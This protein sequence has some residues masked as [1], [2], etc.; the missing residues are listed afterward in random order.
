MKR[1]LLMTILYAAALVRSAAA[2]DTIKFLEP[3]K[4]DEM[5]KPV[6]AA[7]RGK[8]IYALDEKKCA[9]LIYDDGKLTKV[10][11]RCGSEKGAFKSP[12]GVSVG[13]RGRVFVADTGNSRIQI[14]DENGNFLWFFGERGSAPGQLKSPQS[15]AVGAD[16]R[17]FVADTGNDR[18][19]VFTDE[20][21]LL[22]EFGGKASVARETGRFGSPS[23]VV[24]DPSDNIYV[25]DH[26]N[27]RIQ[28]FDASAKFVKDFNLLG[29]DFGVDAYGYFYVLDPKNGKVIEQSPEGSILGKFGSYGS[30][31]GQFK[32]PDGVAVGSDGTIIVLD[33]G[34]NRIQRIEVANKLKT[35]TLPVNLATKLLVTGP[36]RVW[37]VA[38][39][40]LAPLDDDLY[41]YLPK[42]GQFAILD[43]DGKEKKRFGT[44]QGKTPNVTRGTLGFAASRKMGLLF[45]A[46]NPSNRLQ[47]FGLDGAW[48]ANLAES[49]GFFDSKKK[50]GRVKDPRGVA[51][52]DEGTIYIADTGNQRVDAFSPEGVFL[53]GF[54]PQLGSLE[55]KEPTSVAWDKAGF[56]YFAD[57]GL[58]RV[59]KTEPS[60]ALITTYGEEGDGPGQFQS[61]SAIAFDGNNYLYVLD[62]QH[63]RVSVFAKDGRW[64]TDLFAGG[65]QERE[66]QEP[67][68]IAVQGTRLM[69][70]DKGKKRVVSY[71]LHPTLAAP[72]AITTATKDGLASLAWTPIAD[73]WTAGYKVYRSTDGVSFVEVGST[74]AA[75]YLD[76]TVVPYEKYFYKVA[77]EAKTKDVG[78][79]SAAVELFVAGS[80]NKSPVEIST[81]TIGNIFSS[82]YKWYLKNP[83][84][85]LTLT[86]NVNLAFQNV[87][88]TF[89]LKDFMD[90]GYDTEIKKLSP[91]QT[92]DIPLI[93]TLNNKILE[94]SEDTP[95]Q[96]EFT[97]TYFEGGKQQVVSLTKSLRVYSRNAI[98]WEEPRR[99]ANF[100]TPKDP[101]I[102][103]FMRESLRSAPKK[104][105]AET[106]NRNLVTTIQLWD[107][108]SEA[109]V[110]FFSNPNSPYEKISEDPNFPVDYTQFPRETLKRR[111]GQCDDLVTLLISMLDGAKVRAA[112]LDYPG[113]MA[114]M[115][116]TES[117]DPA[118]I[119]LSVDRLIKHGDSYWIPVEATL[120]GK[121]FQEAAEKGLFSYKA[122]SEKGKV[123]IIDVRQAWTDFEPATLPAVD[124]NLE[125]P[126]P[127]A[128]ERRYA[129]EI[130]AFTSE[131][132]KFLKTYY[133]GLIKDDGKD[134]D[135]R[136]QLGLVELQAGKK[137]AAIEEF[138]KILAVEPKNASALTNLGNVAFLAGENEAAATQ[139]L[140]ASEAEPDDADIWLN[141]FK[142]ELRLKNKDK[143]REYGQKA[144]ALD[145]SLEPAVE[146]MLK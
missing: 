62:D 55:M 88:V 143:A 100:I 44:K 118:E 23:R 84:G 110:K 26:G 49:T 128:R 80:F 50:E 61:P 75:K 39:E 42:E 31:P 76:Q 3:I 131:R 81:I 92:V 51:I 98:T 68:A 138:N 24:V 58:K 63:R 112:I 136:L 87:K 132:Y 52:N 109:G 46:D 122:E 41:A 13:T 7:S 103:E 85:K 96:A 43:L 2:Y 89:R 117:A 121:P 11:G 35:A 108:L 144:V 123:K 48:K 134:I 30:G 70:A 67:V 101:P 82:N 6:A 73:S 93:A 140:K 38:A 34:N 104:A 4:A 127:A 15:V 83:I 119:G 65:K 111:T 17:V 97:L 130:G 27:D 20:G 86:N 64:M 21:I 16:G 107:S 53:F 47:S 22:F 78:P 95:I 37:N 145:K 5:V 137:D 60:G 25:L 135:S 142:T 59:F 126:T 105:G 66:L 33:T 74:A 146:N 54:G 106:L 125:V 29:T 124:W 57:K 19:Q 102:L 114:L 69:I 18:I 115:F 90:F 1:K 120:I 129:E 113:H 79:S 139:Y 116:D 36:S 133:Q 32:K 14:L 8:R 94:V 99:I 12:Q 141:L 72:V 71:D 56:V 10:V 77:T 91:Q 9:L 40:V 45:V 28:K